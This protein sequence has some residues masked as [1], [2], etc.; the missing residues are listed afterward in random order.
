M[1]WERCTAIEMDP[2]AAV[3]FEPVRPA[4]RLTNC[5]SL[6]MFLLDTGSQEFARA[7]VRGALSPRCRIL[8][9]CILP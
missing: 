6:H 3:A 8:P 4:T 5:M 9:H 7:H 2:Y 1:T